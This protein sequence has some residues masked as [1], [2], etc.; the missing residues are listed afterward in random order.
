MNLIK[1]LS[2]TLEQQKKNLKKQFK[3]E[4]EV[5]S[6]ITTSINTLSNWYAF[7]LQNIWNTRKPY[8]IQACINWHFVAIEVKYHKLKTKEPD[9]AWIE[10]HLEL[11]Q[12]INLK[13]ISQCSWFSYV[14]VYTL[15]SNSF[16][17]F[18]YK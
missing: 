18:E 9:K 8:D 16:Y 13:K 10:K 11:H 2:D 14:I 5:S 3:N 1:L 6:F 7:I 17:I 15:H 12:K 4:S